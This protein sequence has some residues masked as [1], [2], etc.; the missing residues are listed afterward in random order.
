MANENIKT[1]KLKTKIANATSQ[2]QSSDRFNLR[3]LG[4]VENI[5]D[6][7]SRQVINVTPRTVSFENISHNNRRARF[8]D[9]G[10]IEPE[11]FTVTFGP[12]DEGITQT[13]LMMQIL[14]QKKVDVPEFSSNGE[15][16]FDIKIEYFNIVGEVTHFELYKRCAIQS[17]DA[18]D[19]N[20]QAPANT[21][22][23]AT[24]IFD[25]VRY[26]FEDQEFFIN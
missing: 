24:F 17:L 5:S 11:S 16:V 19:L 2:R 9:V 20:M 21:Q 14:R 22:I 3:F 8:R 4:I 1:D 13:I 12:D 7:L 25:E 6:F 10:K 15:Q 26:S 23:T 18:P